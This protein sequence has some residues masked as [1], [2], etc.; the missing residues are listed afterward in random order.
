MST[1]PNP[2]LGALRSLLAT[3]LATEVA[4]YAKYGQLA[5]VKEGV[6]AAVAW[7]LIY[8]PCEGAILP[9]RYFSD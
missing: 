7:N 3:A 1:S 4:T 5:T 9:V 6:Q 8:T 2:S